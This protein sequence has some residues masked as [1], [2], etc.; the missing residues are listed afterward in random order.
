MNSKL[1]RIG[2][3]LTLMAGIALAVESIEA[4]IELANELAAEHVSVQTE[5][6]RAVADKVRWAGALF[7]G[8]NTPEAAGDYLAGPSQKTWQLLG[9]RT[10]LFEHI[11]TITAYLVF[12]SWDS[13][14]RSIRTGLPP[15]Q[16]A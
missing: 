15:P 10:R 9:A 14:F 13:L 6:A 3:L 2:V 7:I 4:L 11:R 5:N 12:P 16:T 8:H 1:V